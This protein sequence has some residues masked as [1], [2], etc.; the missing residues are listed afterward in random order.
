[1]GSTVDQVTENEQQQL[2]C[3]YLPTPTHEQDMIQG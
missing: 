1:M 3:I 2:S